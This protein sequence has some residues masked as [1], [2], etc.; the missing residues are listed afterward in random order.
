M[1]Y[2]FDKYDS[3]GED[4]AGMPANLTNRQVSNL[5]VQIYRMEADL[6]LVKGKLRGIEE[7]LTN[8]AITELGDLV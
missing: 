5:R 6:T 4:Y 3:E 2:T 8:Q 7:Y 1:D